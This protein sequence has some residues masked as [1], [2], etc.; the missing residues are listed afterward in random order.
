MKERRLQPEAPGPGNEERGADRAEVL[1][2][3]AN[4]KA[5]P[6]KCAP[7]PE[8]VVSGQNLSWPGLAWETPAGLTLH[9]GANAKGAVS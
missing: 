3:S 9:N 5:G 8:E 4:E 2:A 7:G 1:L 6:A